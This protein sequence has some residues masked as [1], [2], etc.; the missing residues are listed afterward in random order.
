MTVCACSLLLYLGWLRYLGHFERD[1]RALCLSKYS[2]DRLL[3]E[4]HLAVFGV[5][6]QIGVGLVRDIL[7]ECY[8]KRKL[9][10]VRTLGIRCRYFEN[11]LR[12]LLLRSLLEDLTLIL[13]LDGRCRGG[14]AGLDL[15]WR[16]CRCG[17]GSTGSCDVLDFICTRN[18]PFV[19]AFLLSVVIGVVENNSVTFF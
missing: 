18:T 13:S 4:R 16:S 11:D 8:I 1:R 17:A 3:V 19:R 14:A 7:H 9:Y 5:H 12:R 15:G 2:L 10:A 6:R